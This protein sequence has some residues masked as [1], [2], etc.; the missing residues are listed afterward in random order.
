MA[1]ISESGKGVE[2][3]DE[4]RDRLPEKKVAPIKE[5]HFY[6]IPRSADEKP[7]KGWTHRRFRDL[8]DFPGIFLAPTAQIELVTGIPD[9]GTRSELERRSNAQ[10]WNVAAAEGNWVLFV[11]KGEHPRGWRPRLSS[12]KPEIKKKS[13]PKEPEPTAETLKVEAPKAPDPSPPV[14]EKVEKAKKSRRGNGFT[15]GSDKTRTGKECA[16]PVREEGDRCRYHGG[17]AKDGGGKEGGPMTETPTPAAGNGGNVINVGIPIEIDVEPIH[18]NVSTGGGS[19]GGT[20]PPPW[21]PPPAP[22]APPA[23]PAPPTI[24]MVPPMAPPPAVPPVAHDHDGGGGGG[25]WAA[26]AIAALVLGGL[27]LFALIFGSGKG[28]AVPSSSCGAA[29]CITCDDGG[30]DTQQQQQQQIVIIV[31]DDGDERV[32]IVEPTTTTRPRGGG[33]TTTTTTTP[34]GGTTTTTEA[35][36]TTQAGGPDGIKPIAV[37][38]GPTVVTIQNGSDGDVTVNLDGSSSHEDGKAVVGWNWVMVSQPEGSNLGGKSGVSV[39][40]TLQYPGDYEFRLTVTDD[41]GETDSTT[42]TI[43]VGVEATG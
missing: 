14:E 12:P 23:T 30:E 21:Y 6:W 29:C 15:C 39:Q 10:R 28:T 13:A 31:D 33:G 11:R 1:T 38:H 24:V 32:V 42:H 9:E 19:G 25:A 36:T 3:L 26:V 17:A 22:P 41:D 18:V 34:A 35:T 40:Y 4:L 5:H 27:V 7:P 8:P 16:F 43:K 20:P 2:G 37:I